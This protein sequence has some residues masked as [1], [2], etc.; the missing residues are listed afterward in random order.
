MLTDS[1]SITVAIG[2]SMIDDHTITGIIVDP[3]EGCSTFT[4]RFRGLYS[5]GVDILI[6]LER[7]E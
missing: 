5:S 3:F 6:D 1:V 2:V 7:W 4:R